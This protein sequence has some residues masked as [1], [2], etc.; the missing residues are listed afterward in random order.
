MKAPLL[1]LIVT[2]SISSFAQSRITTAKKNTVEFDEASLRQKMKSDGVSGEVI[3]KLLDQRKALEKS[4]RKVV[5]VSLKSSSLLGTCSDLG[6]EN[7]WGS[8]TGTVGTHNATGP[9]VFSVPPSVPA[10]PNFSIT[11]GASIDPCT[12]GTAPGSPT[13]PIVASG[14]GDHSISIGEPQTTGCVAEQLI[15]P[16]TV[17]ASDTDL[18]FSYA[19]VIQDAGH[20]PGEQ[21][22][23]SISIYDING[24]PIPCGSFTFNG[25]PSMPGFYTATCGFGT[26]YMPWTTR[27]VNLANYIGQT[28]NVVITNADCSQCGHFAHSY[29]DFSCGH[30]DI[31]YCT[32]QLDSLCAPYDSVISYSYTWF[33]NGIYIPGA[34]SPC[35]PITPQQFDTF[36]VYVMQPSGCD[37]NIQYFLHDTCSGYNVN[38]TATPDSCSKNVG[39][40]T[41]S[42]LNGTAPFTYLWQP[43]GQTTQTATGLS[44][45][46]YTVTVIDANSQTD[47]AIVVVGSGSMTGSSSATSVSC[48]GGNNGTATANISGGLGPYTY[49]WSNGQNAQTATGL[50]SGNYSVVV[51]DVSGCSVTITALVA[52]A[53]MFTS[54]LNN[55]PSSC[56]TCPDGSA[57]TNAVG[58][59]AP[60]TYLWAPGG[61]T[62]AGIIGLFPGGYTVCITDA[63]NCTHCDSVYVGVV[64]MHELTSASFS[65]FPVPASSILYLEF[66]SGNFGEAEVGVSTILG[67]VVSEMNLHASGTRKLDVSGLAEGIYFVKIRTGSGTVTKKIV[68]AK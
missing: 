4:G 31:S 23:V 5:S 15:F 65:I 24:N 60:F 27:G 9:P 55:T 10:A 62:T 21:P 3:N 67:T 42:V 2:I 36:S 59:I 46:T 63:N 33:H 19:M 7:G 11:A 54:N 28:L 40:A 61:Q 45:G 6:V 39:T 53:P 32:G 37:F 48:F 34:T 57:Y 41:A 26:Y 8:W 35:L 56:A 64:G 43:N 47:F 38:A 13:I 20:A 29:W 25:G 44:G 58:G 22:F 1:F 17:T 18:L 49:Q 12:P 50:M 52:G 30:S 68:V 66:S 16:L 51:T 14:F